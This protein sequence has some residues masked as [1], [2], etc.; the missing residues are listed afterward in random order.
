MRDPKRIEKVLQEIGRIWHENPDLRLGQLIGN[1]LEG[2]A[3]YYIEDDGLVSALKDFYHGKSEAVA[4]DEEAYIW[5]LVKRD[6]GEIGFIL[7]A[8]TYEE[9]VATYTDIGGKA[10]DAIFNETEFKAI[11]AYFPDKE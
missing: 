2:A 5:D 10:E 8:K 7:Q 6:P 4:F 1:V 9:Y 3:L 11:K